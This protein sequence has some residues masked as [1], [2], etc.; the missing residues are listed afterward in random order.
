MAD[1]SPLQDHVSASCK[2]MSVRPARSF[3]CILQ[4][5][6]CPSCKTMS[7]AKPCL[8]ILQDRASCKTMSAH[9]TRHVC[10]SCK[11]MSPARSCLCVLQDHVCASCKAMSLCPARPCLCVLQDNVCASCKTFLCFL[12]DMSVIL[13]DHVCLF[14]NNW[15]KVQYHVP[16]N[17]SFSVGKKL[18]INAH[19]YEC[20]YFMR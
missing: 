15:T 20:N 1:D 16:I 17:H 13:Q 5:H 4:D 2:T 6:V 11:T 19:N 9:P 18:L 8:S 14:S 7:P 12:Q 3:L 10:P